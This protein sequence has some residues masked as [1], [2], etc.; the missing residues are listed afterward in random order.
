MRPVTANDRGTWD[1]YR[2]LALLLCSQRV[3]PWLNLAIQ[4]NGLSDSGVGQ[5]FHL[6]ALLITFVISNWTV[7]AL[8]AVLARLRAGLDI[9]QDTRVVF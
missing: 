2:L 8:K 4:A 7:F 5:N 1:A 9:G 6:H 3:S